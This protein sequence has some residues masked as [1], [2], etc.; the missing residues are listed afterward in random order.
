M[1]RNSTRGVIGTALWL[2]VLAS[3]VFGLTFVFAQLYL[4]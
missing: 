4:A 3:F 2:A 1:D